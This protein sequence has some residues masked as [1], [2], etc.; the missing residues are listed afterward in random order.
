MEKDIA[1]LQGKGDGVITNKIVSREPK[2][3]KEED[4]E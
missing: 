4:V 2:E 1:V 3:E